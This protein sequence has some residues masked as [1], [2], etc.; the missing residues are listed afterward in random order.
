MQDAYIRPYHYRDPGSSDEFNGVGVMLVS[1]IPVK[2][3]TDLYLLIGT[4]CQD[5]ISEYKIRLQEI[6]HLSYFPFHGCERLQ[7][8]DQNTKTENRDNW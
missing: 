2:K 5:V 6:Y 4:R 1:T 3:E 8:Y 7:R